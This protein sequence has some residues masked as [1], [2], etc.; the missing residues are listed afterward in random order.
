MNRRISV[1]DAETDPFKHGRVPMPFVWGYYNGEEYRQ[2]TKTSDLGAF[3]YERDEICYAHNGGKF[4]FHYLLHLLEP[5]DDLTI[6]NG[7]IAQCNVGL[8]ELRDSFCIV[9]VAL[10]TYKKDEIDYA[11]MERDERTKSANWAKIESYLKTDCVALWELVTAFTRQFGAKLTVA[12]AAME[13]WRKIAPI[14]DDR[15]NRAFYENFAPYYYGGRVQCFES[16]VIDTD[17]SVYDINSAYP[18]AMMEK[19]PYSSGYVADDGYV[20]GADF[21]RLRCKSYGA[22]PFRGE[23]GGGDGYGLTFP[24]DGIPREYTVTGWEVKAGIE[25]KTIE[26]LEYLQSFRFARHVSFESYVNK[27][28]AAR[29]QAKKEGDTLGMIFNK[30]MMNSLYGKFAAN[31]ENYAN[32][33][34]VPGDDATALFEQGGMTSGDQTQPWT[35]AG[36]IGCWILASKQ[37]EEH[38]QRYYNVATG[39]SITGYVRAMLWRAIC[40]CK[41]VLYCD[42]DSIAVR[43]IGKLVKIGSALGEWKHE[44]DFDK[45]G[46]AGKKL[47]IFRGVN[48]KEGRDY[49]MA[50]KG[51]KLTKAELWKVARGCAVEYHNAAP[52][53]SIKKDPAFV[54]RRIVRTVDKSN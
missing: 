24:D 50:S 34:I 4:D 1:I 52:T 3:L 16:G 18:R 20:A 41:G 10:A 38:E 35:F 31:P 13:Q 44:G 2:F 33:M 36:E 37:L 53:F 29:E 7:R 17:F 54:S 28:W 48:T 40:S 30:L 32:Y 45:A 9:P 42:T 14:D 8:C 43:R 49:K 47:Y 51:V 15:T 12:S 6:I 27:F 19:H 46:I 5:Y 11:I 21:Y 23:G 39:A 26:K 22:L 25:T